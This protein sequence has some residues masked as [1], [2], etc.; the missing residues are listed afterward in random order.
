MGGAI[1]VPGNLDPTAT[2]PAVANTHAEWNA[3]FDP[4]A[5]AY[6]LQNFPDINVF[7]LDVTNSVDRAVA[8]L[9]E[10][11]AYLSGLGEHAMGDPE[12]VRTFLETTGERFMGA[13]AAVAFELFSF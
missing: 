12:I 2:N 4:F 13:G 1:D 9:T 5:V 8:S 10:H 3:F 11:K 6:A 7:P